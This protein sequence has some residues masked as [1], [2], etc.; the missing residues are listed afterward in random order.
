MPAVI[1]IS[2]FA[3]YVREGARAALTLSLSARHFCRVNV[4]T[5]EE[6]EAQER[7]AACPA[8]T[9]NEQ[10]R[11]PAPLEPGVAPLFCVLPLHHWGE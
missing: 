9:V 4:T 8:F 10:Q 5:D 11:G 1:T 2:I 6:A 3:L 7:E